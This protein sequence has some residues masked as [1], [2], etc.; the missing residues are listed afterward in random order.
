MHGW[1]AVIDL[2]AAIAVSLGLPLLTVV[3][4]DLML[5]AANRRH[6]ADLLPTA[7]VVRR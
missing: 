7:R 2:A 4:A 1:D 6:E 5:S 3:I